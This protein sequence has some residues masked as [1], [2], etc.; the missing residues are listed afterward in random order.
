MTG[1]AA[2]RLTEGPAGRATPIVESVREAL[3]RRAP[4]R[5]VGAGR[6]LD[7][8]RPVRAD[9]SLSIA[10]IAGI[11]EYVP[12][13]LTLTAGAGTTLGEI[14]RATAPH[15][16]WLTLDPNGDDS[17]TLGATVA[18]A[19]A[20]PLATGFGTPRDIVLG[21][22]FV[23]GTGA[24]VRGGGRVVKNVAGFDLVRLVTGAWGTLGALTEV[25]VRLRARPEVDT[26]VA[27]AVDTTPE[28]PRELARPLRALAF[29]PYA[30]EV[31]N[32][33]LARRLGLEG[34]LWLLVRLGGSE[35]ALRAQ[36]AA[37]SAL[38]EMRDVADDTWSSLRDA[39]SPGAAC[40]RLSRLPSRFADTWADATRLVELF[41]DALVHGAPLRGVVR[42]IVPDVSTARD[43][44]RGH[45]RVGVE[46]RL[47]RALTAPFDGTRVFERAPGSIWRSFAPS[48]VT[49]RLSQG[50]KAAYDPHCLLNPGILGDCPHR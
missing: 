3:G 11:V 6:W 8:G 50:I 27:I 7:A 38:G 44:G 13:D 9:A 45:A 39:E 10:P 14:A 28:Y 33:T 24:V 41:P 31:V 18:T 43:G 5:I 34:R 23:T 40:L 17:G 47:A 12:G 37:V 2:D 26:T 22:E 15:G 30:A 20:G 16:Q 46:E 4:L 19:S 36:R 35:D 29:T 42:C 32:A 21:V 1:A 25:T 48:A 49:D